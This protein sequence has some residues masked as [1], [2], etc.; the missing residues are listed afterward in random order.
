MSV[1]HQ[2][3]AYLPPLDPAYFS[4]TKLTGFDISA[5]RV[6]DIPPNEEL[7][8]HVTVSRINRCRLTK[9]PKGLNFYSNIQTIDFIDNQLT[10]FPDSFFLSFTNLRYLNLTG[11]KIQ[12]I[13]VKLPETLVSIDVSY[14]PNF[15]ISSLFAQNLPNLKYLKAI[16]CDLS[17]LPSQVPQLAQSLTN[18]MLDGNNFTEFPQV[19]SQYP[20]LEEIGLF[21]NRISTF[22]EID[23]PQQFKSINLSYNLFEQFDVKSKLCTHS[24]NLSGNS[25]KEFPMSLFDITDLRSIF[26][27]RNEISGELKIELPTSLKTFDLSHNHITKLSKKFLCS[28][29]TLTMLN[30][31]YNDIENVKDCIPEGH[32]LVKLYINNNQ[33]KTLPKSLLNGKVL[34]EL[35]ISNN[36]IKELPEF[37]LPQLRTLNISF[38]EISSI[39]DCFQ[40]C[41]MLSDINISFNKLKELPQSMQNCRKTFK[42]IG[43]CNEFESIP[44]QIF[45]FSKLQTLVMSGNKL[46][47]LPSGITSLFFMKALDLSN[48]HFIEIPKVLSK[49]PKLKTLSL[50]HNAIESIPNDFEFP[51]AL[52]YLDLSYNKIKSLPNLELSQL[53]CLSLDCN[54]LNDINI[55]GI[56][57]CKFLSLNKN[58]IQN[59]LIK[60]LPQIMTLDELQK[61]EYLGNNNKER[62]P[63]LTFN[64]MDDTHFSYGN[65]FSVGYSSTMGTRPNMEDSI[66]IK[67]LD[68]N[69][70]IFAMLDGHSGNS[71]STIASNC[72]VYE[73]S[74]ISNSNN[75]VEDLKLAIEN[76]NN[77]LG[78]LKV[79]DGTTLASAYIH[80]NTCYV[81][82]I[83]DSRVIRIKK[84]GYERITKDNKPLQRDELRRLQDKGLTVNSEGRI[85]RKLAVSRSLGDFWISDSG[86]FVKPEIKSFEIEDDDV[87]LIIACDGIWDVIEDEYA[88]NIVREAKSAT[89]AA[90][91]LK[92]YAFSLQSKDN[93]TSLIVKFNPSENESGFFYRNEVE[94]LPPHVDDEKEDGEEMSFPSL[95]AAGNRRR[96]R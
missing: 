38:N 9:I 71:S 11:N 29:G 5:M 10:Q 3:E 25:L 41:L 37:E 90:N 36:K 57:N 46:N 81:I 79:N 96:R 63:P 93:I 80:N 33:L 30:V 6:P 83:G 49:V 50:S 23:F 67:Q 65:K 27:S 43:T 35:N 66:T 24:I 53:N 32:K 1:Q 95:P 69:N 74:K 85:N 52:N 84:N 2:S 4:N 47:S 8:S 73:L 60:L 21:G 86:M 26:I 19:L 44:K 54:E 58:P 61:L 16:S 68:D 15:N 88:A 78:L 64:I 89:D 62:I 34:E 7:K 13:D 94:I 14:N 12:K 39:P 75:I 45:S 70:Y 28:M 56:T 82:G 87:A 18:I 91:T 72:L 77:V 31:S 20:L 42:F 40:N 59:S 48:N 92:N 51:E 17:E 76:V 55:E 22:P